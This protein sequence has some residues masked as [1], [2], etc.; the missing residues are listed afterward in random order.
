MPIF[1]GHRSLLVEK[2]QL[3]CTESTVLYSVKSY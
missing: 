2:K 1:Q 3:H